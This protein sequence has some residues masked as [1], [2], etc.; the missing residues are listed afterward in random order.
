MLVKMYENPCAK[1]IARNQ[2]IKTRKEQMSGL[3]EGDDHEVASFVVHLCSEQ[4]VR[5]HRHRGG[6]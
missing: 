5:H 3:M 2:P 4:D 1:E 6:D